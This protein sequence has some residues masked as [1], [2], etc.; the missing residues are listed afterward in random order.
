MQPV[1]I[2]PIGANVQYEINTMTVMDQ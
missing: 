2:R 1:P